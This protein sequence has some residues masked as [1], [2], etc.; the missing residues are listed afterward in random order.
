[1]SSSLLPPRWP[2]TR[3]L[4]LVGDELEYQ[5]GGCSVNIQSRVKKHGLLLDVWNNFNSEAESL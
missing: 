4:Q 5:E 1:M 2:G 3:Y